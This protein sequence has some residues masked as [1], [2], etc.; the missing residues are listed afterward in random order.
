M[1][2]IHADTCPMSF[3]IL[4]FR[5]GAQFRPSSWGRLCLYTCL[6]TL[7]SPGK[8]R[9]ASSGIGS[10]AMKL[11][12]YEALVVKGLGRPVG[13][14]VIWIFFTGHPELFQ[15]AFANFQELQFFSLF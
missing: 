2:H 10:E 15:T 6:L 8:L 11:L 13:N 5:S 4:R 9:G 12:V 3:S 7:C 14:A 1:A